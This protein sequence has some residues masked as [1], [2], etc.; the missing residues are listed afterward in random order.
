MKN[1]FLDYGFTEEEVENRVNDTFYEITEGMDRFYFDGLRDTSY[2]MDTGNCDARTEG[3]SYGMMMAVMMNNKEMFDRMWKFS[4]EFMY[5][6]EGFLKG[7]FAWSVAPD[8]KKNYFGPAPDGE[9][10]YAMALFLA[11]KKWGDGEGIYE[12]SKW[13][14]KILHTVLH[15][16]MPMWKIDEALVS[17]VPGGSFS[18]PSYHLMHFYHYFAMWADDVDRPF[19][20]RAEEASRKFLVKACHPKTGMNPEYANYDAT[21]NPYGPPEN[22]GDFY[23]DAYRT[24]A[25][26]GLDVLWHGE[27]EDFSVIADNLINFFA[28]IPTEDFKKY[29][30]DG[31]VIKTASGEDEKALHPIGLLATLAQTTLACSPAARRNAEKIVRRFWETPLRTGERRYY[32]N[33]L[34]MFAMLALSG[35]YTYEV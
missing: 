15:H 14:K 26:I 18:D 31:T 23:S 3:M 25:N 7:Y 32:D 27:N 1:T 6:N 30:I 13:A 2:F 12:Y 19:W 29:K 24:G 28:D 4:M 21:P 5:M 35:K 17:F 34:Y 9:E 20:K 22:H 8:G 16:K 33:C 10:F 11:G